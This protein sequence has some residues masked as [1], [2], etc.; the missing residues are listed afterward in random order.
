MVLNFTSRTWIPYVARDL[1]RYTLFGMAFTASGLLHGVAIGTIIGSRPHPRRSVYRRVI[2]YV[3]GGATCWLASL[4]CLILYMVDPSILLGDG[5]TGGDPLMQTIFFGKLAEG[6]VARTVQRPE[7]E[8]V[9][10]VNAYQHVMKNGYDLSL[11]ILYSLFFV[12]A[13]GLDA[14]TLRC[15]IKLLRSTSTPAPTPLDQQ[16]PRGSRSPA[17]EAS[18]TP[19][20][21]MAPAAAAAPAGA[22]FVACPIPAMSFAAL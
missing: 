4:T 14:V 8:R 21:G 19:P 20:M 2:A 10:M 6:G 13:I 7:G 9:Y 22:N 1:P 16:N 11:F 17:A 5:R 12:Y 3:I 15:C 18:A